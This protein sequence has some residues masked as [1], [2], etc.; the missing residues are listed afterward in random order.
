MTK[1]RVCPPCGSVLTAE[2]DDE[3]VAAVQEHARTRHGAD[4]ERQHILDEATEA[5]AAS[6]AAL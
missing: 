5:D 3:L 1:Q 2:T 4:V 6:G